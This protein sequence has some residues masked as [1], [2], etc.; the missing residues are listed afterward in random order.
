MFLFN[1]FLFY[2]TWFEI[3]KQ[4]LTQFHISVSYQKR[5]TVH[6]YLKIL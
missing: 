3:Q 2:G 1:L 5:F 4:N 6:E